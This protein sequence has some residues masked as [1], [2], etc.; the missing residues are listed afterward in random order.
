MSAIMNTPKIDGGPSALQKEKQL[1]RDQRPDLSRTVS[2]NG[3]STT[4]ARH[5]RGD[6]SATSRR[7]DQITSRL[8]DWSKVSEEVPS[9]VVNG[10]GDETVNEE[11][12]PPPEITS[13][14][15]MATIK[16]E[17]S[18]SDLK[19]AIQLYED[20]DKICRGWPM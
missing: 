6:L 9:I 12:L 2:C 4:K 20:F 15:I 17:G 19:E 1:A 10:N 3:E 13:T 11:P 14:S 16:L 18:L 5:F 7:S 8:A